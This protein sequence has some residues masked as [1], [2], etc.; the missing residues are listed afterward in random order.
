[1][2]MNLE[3]SGEN[4]APAAVQSWMFS[5][6][7]LDRSRIDY[8]EIDFTNGMQAD[9]CCSSAR[10]ADGHRLFL[11]GFNWGEFS[12]H[13]TPIRSRFAAVGFAT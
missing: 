11:S 7:R 3:I 4:P 6:L 13:L 8:R 2:K 12:L 9:D 1:M 10:Q 5:R